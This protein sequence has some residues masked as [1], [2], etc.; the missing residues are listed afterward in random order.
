M[1][2]R[3]YDPENEPIA[4]STRVPPTDESLDDGDAG[5]GTDGE[6]DA[7]IVPRTRAP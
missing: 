5:R 4:T 3:P 6:D 1:S 7:P 2:D